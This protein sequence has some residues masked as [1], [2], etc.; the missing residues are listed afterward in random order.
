MSE[1]YKIIA[2]DMDGTLLTSE[3][4]VASES[5]RDIQAAADKGINVVYS[6]GR[7]IAEL[8]PYFEVLP[9]MR[10]AVCYSGAIVYDCIDRKCVYRNEIEQTYIEQIVKVGQEHKAMIH[11]LTEQDSIVSAHDITHMDDF[12]MGVYQSL[13]NE[14]AKTVEDMAEEGRRHQSIPKINIYFRSIKDRDKS[15]EQLK[16][17]PLTF[18]FAENTSLEMTAANVSK[19]TGIMHLASILGTSIEHVVGIGDADNDLDMLSNVGLPVAMANA[20]DRVKAISK[21]VTKDNDHN[22]VGEAIRQ[23]ISTQTARS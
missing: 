20:N 2:V 10:Y 17:L 3:K 22:G 8:K 9:M 5:V 19:A 18:A 6:T 11:F 7:A 12:G 23:I 16:Y 14:V 15:Y 1:E 4:T 13:Y 21:M